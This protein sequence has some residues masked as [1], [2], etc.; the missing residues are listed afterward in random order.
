MATLGVPKTNQKT[1]TTGLSIQQQ[2]SR[3]I[4]SFVGGVPIWHTDQQHV[5]L[6]C[7]NCS[8]AERIMFV[9]QIYAPVGELDRSI[10]V[11][12]CNK[13]AC[14]L[15]S[16]GWTIIRNQKQHI[17]MVKENTQNETHSDLSGV[18]N[19]NSL[20]QAS[21]TSS[22]DFLSNIPLTSL[23]ENDSNAALKQIEALLFARDK[24]SSI[25]PPTPSQHISPPP[26]LPT[27][28]SNNNDKDETIHMDNHRPYWPCWILEDVSDPFISTEGRRLEDP[29]FHGNDN[30]NGEYDDDEDESLGDNFTLHGGGDDEK[31]SKMLEDY[32]AVEEDAEIVSILKQHASKQKSGK[33]G[34]SGAGV[35]HSKKKGEAHK[36]AV[37]VKGNADSMEGSR[38]H[39]LGLDEDES[40]H[41]LSRMDKRSRIEWNFQTRVAMEPR[42]VLRYEY[43]AHPLWC[44]FPFPDCRLVPHCELC[45]KPRVF[46][47]QLMPALLSLLPS[48]EGEHRNEA[49][50]EESD[51]FE[52]QNS[53]LELGDAS[54]V[55]ESDKDIDA[56]VD[57]DDREDS[58]PAQQTQKAQALN[59]SNKPS[60]SQLSKFLQKLGDGIDFGVV[61]IYSCPDSCSTVHATSPA[62]DSF[63][64]EFALVQPPSDIGL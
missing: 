64:Y 30:D 54:Q 50:I 5:S 28:S 33:G 11:F 14:S 2:Q 19:A 58:I 25:Q 3:R 13:R 8:S 38:Q 17:H 7:K 57:D 39:T 43:R 24:G 32:L 12:V 18:R 41:R 46:E 45:G 48:L 60:E 55:T 37:A 27:S 47:M 21:T 52:L 16:A 9:G 63:Q 51:K 35:G 4:S 10:Y 61:A 40:S 42:Q 15:T 22:W 62:V 53:T 31:I 1:K 36:S 44:T 34:N 29:D 20:K 59:V 49:I 26:S 56:F 23:T 6:T